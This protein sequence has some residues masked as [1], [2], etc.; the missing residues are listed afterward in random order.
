ME[1]QFRFA[2]ALDPMQ[3][4]FRTA[5]EVHL[6]RDLSIVPIGYVYTWNPQYGK[7]P[8]KFVND[9][10]RFWQQ[11]SFKHTTGRFHIS[12]RGRLEQRH[13]EVH[14]VNNGEVVY[15]GFK[16]HSN[17]VR[18]RLMVNVPFG[19]K[20]MLPKTVFGSFYNEVFVSW[21]RQI[22]YHKPDQ[23]RVFV[24]VGYQAT[25]D[26]QVTSGVLYQMLI[27]ANGAMQENNIGLQVAM[28]YNPDF[29]GN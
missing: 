1:G 19:K 9:E 23:N 5:A 26:F 14:S 21:G 20:E 24:G 6:T 2:Q 10:H 15:E 27:K 22:T 13:I 25:K 11:V 7:Q 16:R 3:F 17:R 8:N 28:Q 12:H 18:Y 4:Q 29:T